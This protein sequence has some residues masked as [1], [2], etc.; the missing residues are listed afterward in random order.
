MIRKRWFYARY[1]MDAPGK[2]AFTGANPFDVASRIVPRGEVAMPKYGILAARSRNR[3]GVFVL[4]KG[5][6]R[7]QLD[8]RAESACR[9]I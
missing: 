3:K 2:E 1:V 6:E 7:D 8:Y 9:M 4:T 5:L